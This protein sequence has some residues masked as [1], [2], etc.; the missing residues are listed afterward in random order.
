MLRYSF[1]QFVEISKPHIYLNAHRGF[2]EIRQ[3]KELLGKVPLDDIL[4]LVITGHG[5]SHSSY[6]LVELANRNIPISICG[7]NFMPKAIILP[8]EGNSR[9]SMRMRSQF[10]MSKALQKKLWKQIVQNKLKNQAMVLKEYHLPYEALLSMSHSVKSGDPENI[11]AWGA[12][13]Y[14]T[15][16][17]SKDFRRDKE[18][19][20]VNTM[21]NYAYAIIRSCVARGLV[22]AGLHPSV[23]LHH[24]NIYNPMCLVDDLMEPFRPLA[25]YIVKQLLMSGYSTV[26]KE[27]KKILAKIAVTNISFYG[28]NSPLF[29]VVARLSTSLAMVLSKEKK[30]WDIN[31]VIFNWNLLKQINYNNEEKVPSS[32]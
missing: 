27:V 8:I 31:K 25:D 2:L 19:D 6:L 12:R 32:A 22:A 26:N 5:C 30:E 17:F 11:E 28:D 1:G 3:K 20:G 15:T 10:G 4:G 16:L 7:S 24:K 14:W 23:G 21:L 18:A 29:Y 13:R 9:Q